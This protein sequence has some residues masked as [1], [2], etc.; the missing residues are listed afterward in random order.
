MNFS[1]LAEITARIACHFCILKKETPECIILLRV[2]IVLPNFYDWA[3]ASR[4]T[5]LYRALRQFAPRPFSPV[6]IFALL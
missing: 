4:S 5:T 1:T 2:I 3:I 6:D